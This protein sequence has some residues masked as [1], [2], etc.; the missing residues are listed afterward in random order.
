MP[1]ISHVHKSFRRGCRNFNLPRWVPPK[2][3]YSDPGN[4]IKRFE[5]QANQEAREM[6]FGS[7]TPARALKTITAEQAWR[8]Y[9]LSSRELGL[10]VPS[11]KM[12]VVFDSSDITKLFNK[13]E[14]SEESL[15][16]TELVGI[17]HQI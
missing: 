11:I 8:T 12:G 13:F 15:L 7:K 9:G 4:I 5:N 2:D 6:V 17:I 14:V 16:Y 10:L 1:M 3:D